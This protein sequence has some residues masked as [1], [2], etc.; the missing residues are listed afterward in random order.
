MD[1]HY[2]VESSDLPVSCG[3]NE[4]K[5][6]VNA[7][8]SEAGITFDAR[9]LCKN[10][11]VLPLQVADNLRETVHSQR[12]KTAVAVHAPYLASLSI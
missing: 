4:V 3:C 6:D 1:A 5:K 7:I 8:V 9:L 10:I 11:V 12:V 2:S